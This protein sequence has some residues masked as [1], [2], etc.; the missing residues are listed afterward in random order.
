M[1]NLKKD[2][3]ANVDQVMTGHSSANGDVIHQVEPVV[4][5]HSL[6]EPPTPLKVQFGLHP[7]SPSEGRRNRQVPKHYIPNV[8]VD[9]SNSPEGHF[10]PGITGILPSE[11][12]GAIPKP[13]F[14]TGVDSSPKV[15][16]ACS[17]P[18]TSTD[19]ENLS[20]YI[21]TFDPQSRPHGTVSN[22]EQDLSESVLEFDR[23]EGQVKKLRRKSDA[24][25]ANDGGAAKSS[26]MQQLAMIRRKQEELIRLQDAL[27]CQLNKQVGKSEG[28]L[29]EHCQ[30]EGDVA[31]SDPHQ[32]SEGEKC[33]SRTEH[34]T[35]LMEDIQLRSSDAVREEGSPPENRGDAPIV[36]HSP[37]VIVMES[38]AKSNAVTTP[39]TIQQR[40]L[41]G[42]PL[43]TQGFGSSLLPFPQ[44]P[45]RNSH[46]SPFVARFSGSDGSVLCTPS[47]P[48]SYLGMDYYDQAVFSPKSLMAGSAQ[49]LS[50]INESF[51]IQ[52]PLAMFTPSPIKLG[53]N[54]AP[55]ASRKLPV[56]NLTRRLNDTLENFES[57]TPSPKVKRHSPLP[58]VVAP[59]VGTLSLAGNLAPHH[60][61]NPRHQ[62]ALT[63]V[64]DKILG[65]AAHRYCE[66]LLDEE[67]ALFACRLHVTLGLAPLLITRCTDPVASVL[68]EGDDQVSVCSNNFFPFFTF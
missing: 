50:P 7:S 11:Y 36:S 25:V 22:L 44:T 16:Q 35:E 32:T 1:G 42:I 29:T 14:F 46:Y 37:V 26:I 21:S 43:V 23:L 63:S 6:K 15:Y 45:L 12:F 67:V 34:I 20:P 8:L 61:R 48:G 41:L 17:I 24:I 9:V 66:A 62:G 30:E 55:V 56:A 60:R 52:L 2:D 13:P 18:E 59:S 28:R 33:N 64:R 47:T 39:P 10:S 19:K 57:M 3:E 68:E 58:R 27:Q 5:S 4:E 49:I 40:E 53:R 65:S 38:D 54:V 31:S 51:P